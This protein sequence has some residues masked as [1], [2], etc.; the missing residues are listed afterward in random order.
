MSFLSIPINKKFGHRKAVHGFFIWSV[1]AMVGIFWKPA[2]FLGLGALSHCFIDC[3]N[4]SGVQALE[5]F[6]EKVCVLFNRS[7][8]ILAGS[9]KEFFILVIL[10]LVAWSGGYIGTFGGLKAVIGE[11][12]GSYQIAYERYLR[13]GTKICHLEGKLRTAEGNILED[14]WLIIGREGSKG[15]A[16]LAGD[17]ILHIPG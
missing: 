1:L 5:P 15:L 9:R 7:W 3:W 2:L 11:I 10:G 16:I 4:V 6:S 8:R 14:K 13:E 17:K 12:V